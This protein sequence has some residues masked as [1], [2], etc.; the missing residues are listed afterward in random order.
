VETDVDSHAS[1]RRGQA[2]ALEI[3][4]LGPMTVS[5]GG[6][7]LPLPAS[8]KVRALL[9][10]LALAPHPVS[11]SRLCD[12][13][14]D[15]P[16]D[17]RGELRWCLSKIRSLIDEAGHSRIKA[18]A[19][20]IRLDLSGCIVDAVE[21]IR[22][23]ELGVDTVPAERLMTVSAMSAGE[24]LD[25]LELERSPLFDTWLTARRRQ[26][27]DCRA[28]MLERLVQIVPG[29]NVFPHLDAWLQLARSISGCTKPC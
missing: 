4:L 22:A 14:W 7:A 28:A 1:C 9:A 26:L 16:Q 5:R 13:F 24:F 25:G 29:D 27:R 12:L 6:D 15:V 20:A 19:D 3:R 23:V 21:I 8:R 2:P 17:P 18:E 10:Y 11:R